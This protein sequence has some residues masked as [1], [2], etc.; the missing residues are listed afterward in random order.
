MPQKTR[1][2]LLNIG[3][4]CSISVLTQAL[5]NT[6]YPLQAGMSP[7][8]QALAGRSACTSPVSTS[9]SAPTADPLPQLNEF[10]DFKMKTEQAIKGL[11]DLTEWQGKNL[12]D[13]GRL[14]VKYQRLEIRMLKEDGRKPICKLLEADYEMAKQNWASFLQ[15]LSLEDRATLQLNRFSQE[16]IQATQ[17]DKFQKQGGSTAHSSTADVVAAAVA[18][19]PES[20]RKAY[21][22]LFDAVH[23]KGAFDKEEAQAWD[24]S[25]L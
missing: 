15:S 21:I 3:A 20:A 22:L 8:K 2:E 5:V 9:V 6:A 24:N 16:A 14:L 10:A 11:Q 23:G 17:Y 1:Y 4:D 18:N 12:G 7:I 13:Q 19:L 25:D